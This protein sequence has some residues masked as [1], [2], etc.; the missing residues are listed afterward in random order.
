LNAIQAASEYVEFSNT[1]SGVVK[2]LPGIYVIV[3]FT[4]A[5]LV[6][7]VDYVL[8]CKY[9]SGAVDFDLDDIFDGH[10]SAGKKGGRKKGHKKDALDKSP[11]KPA[12]SSASLKE[13]GG[14]AE[15]S[16][17][18]AGLDSSPLL[19]SGRVGPAIRIPVPFVVQE[20]EWLEDAEDVGMTAVFDQVS[21]FYITRIFGLFPTFLI[22]F[23]SI[24]LRI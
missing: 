2:L 1:C 3:P 19:V 22:L 5:Q 16:A 14:T 13:A 21:T 9:K 18:S 23:N 17:S 11:S 7:P 24:R 4:D 12:D 8:D 15:L 20:W 10:K 6:F